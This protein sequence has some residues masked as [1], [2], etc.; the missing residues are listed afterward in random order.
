M[1]AET[2]ELYTFFGGKNHLK[3]SNGLASSIIEDDI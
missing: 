1:N 2:F 3:F